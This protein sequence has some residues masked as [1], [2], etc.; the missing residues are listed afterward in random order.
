[1]LKFHKKPVYLMIAMFLPIISCGKEETT[2][3]G[4]AKKKIEEPPVEIPVTIPEPSEPSPTEPSVDSVDVAFSCISDASETKENLPDRV[5]PAWESEASIPLRV[6]GKLC[7]PKEVARKIVV[8]VD[9]SGS[10]KGNDPVINGSCGRLD[11]LNAL[12]ASAGEQTSFAVVTF[13]SGVLHSSTD[14]FTTTDDLFMDIDDK[15]S[16]V[17]VICGA[18]GGTHYDSS[19]NRALEIFGQSSDATFLETYLISDGAPSKA[20]N[21]VEMAKKLRQEG[22]IIG[23]IMLNGEDQVL[24]DQIVSK[25]KEGKPLFSQVSGADTLLT[26]LSDLSEAAEGRVVSAHLSIYGV[27]NDISL[28][29]DILSDPGVVLNGDDF[30]LPDYLI[31]P[32]L[33]AKGYLLHYTYSL[34][35]GSDHNQFLKVLFEAP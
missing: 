15:R 19:L 7:S 1:M 13:S 20:H 8:L 9:V 21:G 26:E 2:F 30:K 23:A 29:V 33:D 25:D 3:T 6:S 24:E 10:M 14:F 5:L 12:M 31:S 27:E 11:A 28:E 4:E 16:P 32:Q 34:S 17:R 22:I 18:S 35:N